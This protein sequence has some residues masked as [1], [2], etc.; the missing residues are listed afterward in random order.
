MIAKSEKDVTTLLNEI[1]AGSA[2][3]PDQ[4]FEMIRAELYRL[5]THA[6]G[7][8]CKDHTLQPTALLHEAWIRL[9]RANELDRIEDRNH[10]LH[11]AAR[12]M[13]QILIDHVRRR[14]AGKRG[15]TWRRV[16]F[17]EVLDDFSEQRLDLQA[18]RE[19][20][21][22]L[23]SLNARQATVMT[24]RIIGGFTAQEVADQLEIPLRKVEVEFRLAR[25]WLRQRLEGNP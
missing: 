14:D 9:F 6:M 12:A 20:L 8:Q 24:L 7:G 25:A 2:G 21:E 10:L 15:G 4:L 23:E 18:M 11:V 17:D 13:R 5:A 1:R 22:E 19:A 3:A 16:P